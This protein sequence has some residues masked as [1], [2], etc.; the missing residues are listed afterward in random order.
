M[1]STRLRQ[2]VRPRAGRRCEYCHFHEDHL[3]LW[4]FHLE[5][6]VAGQ[7]GGG[8]TTENL[9]W[10]CQRCNLR[11][12]PNLTGI[13]PDTDCPVGLFHPREDV[14]SECFSLGADGRIVGLNAAGRATAWLLQMNCAERVEIRRLLLLAGRW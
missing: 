8:D 11:K 1:I 9:A 13:D 5:H 7:H 6:I 4:P 10:S 2:A 12:G 14:W 3:P